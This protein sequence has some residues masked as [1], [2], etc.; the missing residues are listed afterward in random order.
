MDDGHVS[1]TATRGRFGVLL[2]SRCRRWKK[3]CRVTRGQFVAPFDAL[4]WHILFG[5]IAVEVKRVALVSVDVFDSR[6][7]TAVNA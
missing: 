5:W 7:R 2:L 4:H 3:R 6:N 1:T